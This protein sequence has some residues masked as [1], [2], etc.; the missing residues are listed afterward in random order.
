MAGGE[1]VWD[2]DATAEVYDPVKGVFGPVFSPKGGTSR[3]A[4]TATLLS[5]G[6]CRDRRRLSG[7]DAF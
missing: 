1:I 4:H 7:R 2:L 5:D 6:K 3:E